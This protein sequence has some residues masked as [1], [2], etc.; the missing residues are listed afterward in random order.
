MIID[1][2]KYSQTQVNLNGL[3]A[4]A[5]DNNG[6]I[7]A[8]MNKSIEKP[9]KL[10]PEEQKK[11]SLSEKVFQKVN[12]ILKLKQ[13]SEIIKKILETSKIP[14]MTSIG[15]SV[16]SEV[17]ELTDSTDKTMEKFLKYMDADT[18][19]LASA[20]DEA[21]KELADTEVKVK[22]YLARGQKAIKL[23]EALEKFAA[24]GGD[25]NAIKI[26]KIVE[27]ISK[28]V[29]TPQQ[30][31]DAGGA[32]DKSAGDETAAEQNTADTGAISETSVDE[33]IA[34]SAV[35]NEASVEGD[36]AGTI[37]ETDI[38]E[39]IETAAADKTDG[40]PAQTASNKADDLSEGE[41]DEFLKKDKISNIMQK[42]IEATKNND[43]SDSDIA[44]YINE[45]ALNKKEQ[46]KPAAN[47]FGANNQ[48]GYNTNPIEIDFTAMSPKKNPFSVR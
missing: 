5:A 9:K 45:K 24:N 15:L 10:S 38:D 43:F 27:E 19:R 44:D 25:I 17:N 29:E 23:N 28:P 35:I 39:N 41:I 30:S 11:H 4:A 40:I 18:N 8:E 48:A 12:L 2:I 16:D 31:G 3:N 36:I 42:L 6:E 7:A 32:S 22:V 37:N 13:S 46:S 20:V 1:G 34:G 33:N 14:Q 47:L 21:I 26:D